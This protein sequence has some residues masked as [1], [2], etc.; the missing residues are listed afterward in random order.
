MTLLPGRRV[1]VSARLEAAGSVTANKRPLSIERLSASLEGGAAGS[2]A[3]VDLALAAPF[4]PQ[5]VQLTGRLAGVT[6]GRLRPGARL[7][8]KGNLTLS[9]GR[10]SWAAGQP[11]RPYWQ[12]HHVLNHTH[13]VL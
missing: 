3:T 12:S 6:S 2:H 10:G 9:D 4:L 7:D 8:L 1:A 11:H 5:E 13:C